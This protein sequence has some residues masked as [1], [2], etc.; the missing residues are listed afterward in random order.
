MKMIPAAL[1]LSCA[2]AAAGAQEVF[3]LAPNAISGLSYNAQSDNPTEGTVFIRIRQPLELDYAYAVSFDPG[4]SGRLLLGPDPSYTLGYELLDPRYN[5]PRILKAWMD[6]I[7][8]DDFPT[9]LFPAGTRNTNI[10]H[11]FSV[12]VPAG[13]IVPAGTYSGSF[14]VNLYGAP[15]GSPP[16]LTSTR[17]LPVSVVV[18]EYTEIA[19]VQVGAPYFMPTPSQ[20]LDFGQ[21]EEGDQ[22][23]LDLIVRSNVSYSV[24]VSSANGS[25]LRNVDPS[26][27]TPIPYL[28]EA[29]G[30]SMSMPA[31]L[32]VA[33]VNTAPWT[34][35]GEARYRLDFRIRAFDMVSAGEYTDTL[36]FTV[37]AN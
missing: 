18:P 24:S 35:G 4:T 12:I 33:L 27:A 21:L 6:G 3:R 2:L 30:V 23:S 5:P 28:L 32:A 7:Y 25:A 1:I 37:S 36:T 17:N 26:E 14:S 16:V 10:E 8:P 9:G 11:P 34:A 15:V 31:G 13:A 19:V 29:N 22:E 20:T